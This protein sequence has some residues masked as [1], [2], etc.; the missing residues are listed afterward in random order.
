MRPLFRPLCLLPLLLLSL[1]AV[2]CAP[3][4]RPPA[5]P[6]E[7]VTISSLLV[8]PVD[9]VLSVKE[10][11]SDSKIQTL[12]QGATVMDELL[13]AYLEKQEIPGLTFLTENQLEGHIGSR[14]G[15]RLALGV[16]VARDLQKDAILNMRLTRFSERQGNNYSINA[17]ASLAFEYK[18]VRADSGEV[19]CSGSF[20]ESQQALFENLLSFSAKKS[21][22][23]LTIREFAGNALQKK[24]DAC[25]V[26]KASEP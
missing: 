4:Q 16:Q 3:A 7:P 14:T 9:P 12:R 17:P 5:A 1:F 11:P 24:L 6:A 26:L 15:S 20:D 10:T 23:W 18:L 25:P 19:L 21:L 2:S 22:R 8:L 13:A